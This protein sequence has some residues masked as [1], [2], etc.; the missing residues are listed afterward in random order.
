LE[1]N[2]RRTAQ[3]IKDNQGSYELSALIY[4][5]SF[6]YILRQKNALIASDEVTL[7]E[8]EKVCEQIKLTYDITQLDIAIFD[9][10]FTLVPLEDFEEAERATYMTQASGSLPSGRS[11]LVKV[12]DHFDVQASLC[13]EISQDLVKRCLDL[14]PRANLCHAVTSLWAKVRQG[15]K[16]PLIHLCRIGNKVLTIAAQDGQLRLATVIHG[17][18]PV[19]VL[20]Y[21]TLTTQVLGLSADTL[22]VELSGDFV[23]GSSSDQLLRRYFNHVSYPSSSL[24][25]EGVRLDPSF[26]Y[27]LES[28]SI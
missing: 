13:Y 8:L 3:H 25:L 10:C 26:H 5:D 21:V 16:G 22:N 9:E 20:Y 17:D 2:K 24:T 12:D 19:T 4:A 14:H 18:Q 7:V 27:T 28:L 11:K 1:L 23:A 15:Q 6:F